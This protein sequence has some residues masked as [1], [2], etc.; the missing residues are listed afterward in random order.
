MSL[1]IDVIEL[2]SGHRRLTKD[3]VKGIR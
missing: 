1:K 2:Y 3:Q